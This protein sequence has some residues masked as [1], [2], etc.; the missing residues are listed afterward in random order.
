MKNHEA[1]KNHF[2]DVLDSD[3]LNVNK[4][5]RFKMHS[6]RKWESAMEKSLYDTKI[7]EINFR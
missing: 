1:N 7:T 4:K 6:S 2:K 3:S 5:L